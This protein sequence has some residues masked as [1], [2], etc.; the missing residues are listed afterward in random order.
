[1]EY[2]PFKHI[3][4]I[5]QQKM[6]KHWYVVRNQRWNLDIAGFGGSIVFKLVVDVSTGFPQNP[7]PGRDNAP[8]PVQLD[9]SVDQGLTSYGGTRI[10]AFQL[11]IGRGPQMFNV[12]L[13]LLLFLPDQYLSHSQD[14]ERI[15]MSIFFQARSQTMHMHCLE[16]TTCLPRR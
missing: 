9:L 8:E 7:T 6:A 16:N 5:I 14:Q 10:S 15:R 12:L 13:R 11:S 2:E 4:K 1:L 3:L